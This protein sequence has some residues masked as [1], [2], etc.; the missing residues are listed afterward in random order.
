MGMNEEKM[1]HLGRI[2]H[3][4]VGDV[5]CKTDS[6]SG[7]FVREDYLTKAADGAPS[8]LIWMDL[9]RDL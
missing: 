8:E 3:K 1:E 2:V 7:G 4:T 6:F 9:D 5:E